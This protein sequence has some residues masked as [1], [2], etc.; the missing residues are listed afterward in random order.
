MEPAVSAEHGATAIDLA[1]TVSDETAGIAGFEI[2]RQEAAPSGGVCPAT[3]WTD[4]GPP[5]TS[6]VSPIRIT[7]LAP[8]RCYRW[9]LYADD[10][11]GNAGEAISGAILTSDALISSSPPGDVVFDVEP[12]D[13][14][15]A[16]GVSPSSVELLVD[17]SVV[18][19]DSSSP[20]Q[21]A[22]STDAVA[23]GNRAVALRVHHAGG[24][25][26]DTASVQIE[27]DNSL[28]AVERVLA[29]DAKDRLTEDDF[30]LYG[31]YSMGSVWS[32][33][34]RYQSA[35]QTSELEFDQTQFIAN[36]GSLSPEVQAEIDAFLANPYRGDLY[37]PPPTFIGQQLDPMWDGPG[38]D[39]CKSFFAPR[40]PAGV[41]CEHVSK[42]GNFIFTYAQPAGG[43]PNTVAPEDSINDDGDSDPG[44]DP[45]PHQPAR[46]RVRAGT[47]RVHGSKQHGLQPG[48][49]AHGRPDPETHRLR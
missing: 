19:S 7:D 47:R 6:S 34:E 28:P 21:V 30:A 49:D 26:V 25:S 27:V 31:V 41:R 20:F 37:Q 11:A 17:G 5:D 8:A 9:Y 1:W 16:T 46:L 2:S 10:A 29:D 22:W 12:V 18:G 43:P 44:Q 4:V 24:G 38:G 42:D 23:N 15:L 13:A 36:M 35:T 32:L 33:P 45:G 3:G 14:V 40:G 48:A 39:G